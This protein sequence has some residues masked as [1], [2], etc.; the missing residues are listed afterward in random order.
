[1]KARPRLGIPAYGAALLSLGASVAVLGSNGGTV[2]S[3]ANGGGHYLIGDLRVQFAMGTVA[4]E[5]GS[6]T[7]RFHH[8]TRLD[9]Q[10]VEFHGEVTCLAVDPVNHRA[11][12]GGIVTK[13]KSEHPDFQTPIHQPGRDIWFRVVDYGEGA[14]A[15]P[16]RTTF[17]GFEGGG[18]IITSLEYCERRMSLFSGGDRVQTS[19]GSRRGCR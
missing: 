4:H 8:S 12:I 9:G 19:F 16:D 7:G 6:A 11:W 17:V 13:N 15:P 3:S 5:D 18:G 10:R 2:N 14:E 1:M